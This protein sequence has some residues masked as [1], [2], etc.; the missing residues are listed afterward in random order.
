[1]KWNDWKQIASVVHE[2]AGPMP[3]L[4]FGFS[5]AQIV[6]VYLWANY[7]D[8]PISWACRREHWPVFVRSAP[9]SSSTMSRRLRRPE[10]RDL[11]ERVRVR[12]EGPP[13]GDLVHTMDGK[14][15]PVAAHSRDR[16][17]T[18]GGPGGRRRGYR[19]HS[20][21]EV[22]GRRVAY[23]VH[24]L[25]VDETV[26]ARSLL[27]R[28]GVPGYVLGDARYHCE[29]LCTLAGNLGQQL[30]APR[31]RSGNGALGHRRQSPERLRCLDMLER[32][33]T[34]FST[35]L[36]ALRG[37]IETMHAHLTTCAGGFIG[38]PAW[39][40]TLSRVRLYI[41]GKLVLDAARR[42][43]LATPAHAS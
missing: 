1:M 41:L 18:R 27:E 17:A 2:L 29:A 35:A 40:R 36:F 16:E 31:R 34:P 30:L 28:S 20:L 9:P 33:P 14:I 13:T 8:K 23:E 3:N 19:L 21:C 32:S 11:L 15:L 5:D 37:S 26:A 39:V 4:R 42:H 22:G 43:R 7:F 12:L 24:P 6:L 38:L 10:V 25:H